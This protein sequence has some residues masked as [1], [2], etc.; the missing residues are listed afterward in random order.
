[1][2]DGPARRLCDGSFF[3]IRR[4]AN[5]SRAHGSAKER[6]S[7]APETQFELA[8]RGIGSSP[9]ELLYSFSTVDLTGGSTALR[10]H[11]LHPAKVTV[12]IV[13]RA[14]VGDTKSILRP[15]IRAVKTSHVRYGSRSTLLPGF[16]ERSNCRDA[17]ADPAARNVSLGLL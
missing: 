12:L 2:Q 16:F 9:N 8:I 1:M 5:P 11:R 14:G 7:L 15:G 13:N 6:I 4:A 10:S 17:H 3:A